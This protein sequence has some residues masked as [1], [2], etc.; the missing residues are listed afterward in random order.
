MDEEIPAPD[1]RDALADPGPW[2]AAERAAAGALARVAAG[3][4]RLDE[5]LA[6]DAAGPARLAED[7]AVALVR[8]G[9]GRIAREDFVLWQRGAMRATARD[10]G[11]LA[12]AGW[13]ARRLALPPVPG[14]GLPGEPAGLAALLDRPGG[15]GAARAA[16][17]LAALPG[18]AGLHPVTRGAALRGL[19]AATGPRGAPGALEA[20]LLAARAGAAGLDRLGFLPLGALPRVPAAGPGATAA[21]RLAGHLAEAGPRIAA[22]LADLKERAAFREKVARGAAGRGLA[23]RVA[24]ELARRSVADAAGLAA[25]LGA[26]PQAVNA[27]LRALASAGLAEE[28]TGQARFRLWRAALSRPTR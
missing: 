5:R 22:L 9:G 20:A 27:A 6:G 3:L 23:A 18:L 8:A 4:A 14:T 28:L 12:A 26:T 7:E 16:A 2:E 19:W 17:V 11:A 15:A 24:V 21:A 25:A 10:P 1:P 13:L